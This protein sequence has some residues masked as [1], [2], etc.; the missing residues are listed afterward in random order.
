MPLPENQSAQQLNGSGGEGGSTKISSEQAG[1]QL[2]KRRANACNAL[3]RLAAKSGFGQES[4]QW[5]QQRIRQLRSMSNE[6]AI[7]LLEG[8]VSHTRFCTADQAKGS[9]PS[10][11]TAEMH[12]PP[13]I[14]DYPDVA[15]SR[16]RSALGVGGIKSLCIAAK[17][18]V[19]VQESFQTNGDESAV[20]HVFEMQF[21]IPDIYSGTHTAIAPSKQGARSKAWS[22]LV[23]RMHADGSLA[24]VLRRGKPTRKPSQPIRELEDV[25]YIRKKE[26]VV[27]KAQLP[28]APDGL[29]QPVRVQDIVNGACGKAKVAMQVDLDYVSLGLHRG[30]AAFQ[31]TLKLDLSG[32]GTETTTGQGVGKS[33]AKQA[34]WLRM[35][36]RL[37]ESAALKELFPDSDTPER[38][39]GEDGSE[40]APT[41]LTKQTL[42]E[43]KDAK[44]EIY[45]YAAS[46]GHVPDFEISMVKSIARRSL[47]RRKQVSPT[48]LVKATIRLPELGIEVAAASRGVQSA[49]TAAAIEFK[50][51]AEDYIKSRADH[52][53]ISNAF[54]NLNTDTA[55]Y[56][57]DFLQELRGGLRLELVHEPVSVAAAT[58][59]SVGIS[60][61]GEAIGR[62]VTMGTKK[63]AEVV[64]YLV[65]A[66]ELG[67]RDPELMEDFE[68]RMKRDKGKV[69]KS[70]RSVDLSINS[71]VIHTMRSALVEARQAGLPDERE[72]LTAEHS[73]QTRQ[74]ARRRRQQLSQTEAGQL[75]LELLEQQREFM[76]KDSLEEL[77]S[78]KATLP[79]NHYRA[80]VLDMVSNNPYSIIVGA[81][82]SGKTTQVPQI[83]LDQEIAAGTGA[84]CNI[85]CTQPRR[86]AATSVAQRVAIERDQR[87]QQSVGYHVRFDARVPKL[88]GSITYCT[89][90]ILLEQ[91]K[92]DPD[93]V[94]D[95]IS[96]LVI[97]EVHE[98][99]ISID[100]L[101][102]VMKKA[103]AARKLAGKHVPKV[104]LMSATLDTELFANYFATQGQGKPIPCPSLSVPGRTFPVSDQYLGSIMHD[105]LQEHG[106]EVNKV[107]NLDLASQTYV[108]SET[109]F[110]AA[111][112]G[113]PGKIDESSRADSVIDWKRERQSLVGQE[114]ESDTAKEKE[115]ALVPTALAAATVAHI[116]RTTADSGA[117]LVFLPGIEEILRT[118]RHLLEHSIFGL[119]FS[120]TTKFKIYLLHSSIPKED[121]SQIFEPAPAGCRKIIL[122][123]NI[124]ETSVTVTDVKYVVD[125]G[126]LRE[127][128]YDQARR[129][130]KLQCV[131]E[132]KSNAKQR[133]GRA[134]RVQDGFYYALYSKERHE[135]LRA[136]GLP[137]LLRTDLQ[138]TLLSIKSQEFNEP[139][140]TFLMQAIEPPPRHAIVAAREALQAVEA[141]TEDERLTD[142]GRL[143]SKLPVH[144][145][146]GKMIVL[147]VVFRCLDPMLVLG[148]AAEER[149]LFISPIGK[150][151]RSAVTEIRRE[152]SQDE[153][154]DHLASLGAFRELRILK[155]Q[156]GT[157]VAF[158]RAREKYIHFG[159]FKTI[160]QTAQ[161]ILQVL[162][163]SGLIPNARDGKRRPDQYGPAAM[164]RNAQNT[165]LI[166][167]LLAAGL[168]PNLGAK[169]SA[170]GAAYRTTSEQG[171]LMHPSSLND[172]HRLK[173]DG[174]HASGTLFSYSSLQQGREASSL[175][176]RD[177]TLI[178]PLMAALFGGHLQMKG[179]RLEMDSWLPVFVKAGERQFA[180]KL[181]L[182]FR[183]ALD[184]VLNSAYRSLASVKREGGREFGDDPVRER[185]AGS[186]VQVLALAEGEGGA[187]GFGVRGRGREE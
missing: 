12:L 37:Y 163:D 128:R 38:F 28:H 146:L 62:A 101:M 21:T 155:D 95:V 121:Q 109:A 46:I 80:Q 34:A 111:N 23:S 66:V 18:P 91:L 170:R 2:S 82:G 84:L 19:D 72:L 64:A 35:T 74:R 118:Q 89:T 93:G 129:I 183:K 125:A 174:K 17:L 139:V 50:L 97:D 16:V 25:N 57:F 182:E 78:K 176:M 92:H 51:K 70:L 53:G 169:T 154:S 166:R 68:A 58:Q 77:R 60:I 168:Y 141:F 42:A 162:E 22:A 39:V 30:L 88:G 4:R 142:L 104:V 181:V 29:F 153:H 185:F 14:Q 117:I 110:S 20:K 144:P 158:D 152:Y 119:Q 54:S 106:G 131:W 100:F 48:S 150:P 26:S 127:T 124:A 138:E 167:S 103:L 87:L 98:R 151:A 8:L 157:H 10:P 165:T 27:T 105:L 73:D 130:T 134:G 175:F 85:I 173:E 40:V 59:H 161:Q 149:S 96:H 123:T 7:P 79:M 90:G 113:D 184:R 171:I 65:A 115:E 76:T 63:Q 67:K 114:G 136:I 5:L 61:D 36:A 6:E 32:L 159:A 33:A 86:I 43:E 107:L 102:V 177:S 41:L 186:I 148:A 116:C 83:L 1:D 108:R 180:T 81:T 135:A 11:T 71:E 56:F 172:D 47:R 187:R 3:W 99:D 75:N 44:T 52:E 112:T 122:S 9:S 94:L 132:S 137:E 133:A 179:Y 15:P 140:E 156:F 147:G 120:D 69:L 24:K 49:E 178:T 55:R 164:N 145:T 31:C 143:L 126:K 13:T 45:N 160:D